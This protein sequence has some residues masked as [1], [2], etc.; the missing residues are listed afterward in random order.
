MS[1]IKAMVNKKF[2]QKL[3]EV[4][5][6]GARPP[7]RSTCGPWH[8]ALEAAKGADL[9]AAPSLPPFVQLN[10]PSELDLVQVNWEAAWMS[11]HEPGLL[12]IHPPPPLCRSLPSR[13]WIRSA[14]RSATWRMSWRQRVLSWRHIARQVYG[15]PPGCLH[16]AQPVVFSI[17]CACPP[18]RS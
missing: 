12:L 6:R 18:S 9:A 1:D 15:Y 7:W 11:W 17:S 10:I 16:G 3:K 5:R 14:R 8:S 2:A 13:E 4:R